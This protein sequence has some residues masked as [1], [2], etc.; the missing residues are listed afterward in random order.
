[1]SERQVDG[2]GVKQLQDGREWVAERLARADKQA[3]SLLTEHPIAALACAVGIGYL[4]ARLLRLG[5]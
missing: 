5:K 4:A 2:N 1:M 3:R